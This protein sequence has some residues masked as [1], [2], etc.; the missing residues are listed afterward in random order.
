MTQLLRN[1]LVI[2]ATFCALSACNKRADGPF[3]A[4]PTAP[5][6]PIGP[7][8]ANPGASVDAVR[9]AVGETVGGV[10]SLSDRT[11]DSGNSF[12]PPEYCRRFAIAVPTSGVLRVN[13]ASSGPYS[14][15]LG[16]G[17][18]RQWGTTISASVE[19]GSTYEISVALHGVIPGV[20]S[21]S[22]ELTTRLDAI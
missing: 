21:Q 10:V 13:V 7:P 17:P 6:T 8:R 2:L 4:S 16:I 1:S 5:T 18:L 9:I 11:C 19:A 3:L 22:F 15:T 14:L 20:T 12:D